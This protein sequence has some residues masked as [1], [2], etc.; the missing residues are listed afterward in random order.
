MLH[1]RMHVCSTG[2]LHLCKLLL[3]RWRRVCFRQESFNL[4]DSTSLRGKPRSWLRQHLYGSPGRR[5]GKEQPEA[6][7]FREPVT[8]CRIISTARESFAPPRPLQP[9]LRQ[10]ASARMWAAAGQHEPQPAGCTGGFE[11][12]ARRRASPMAVWPAR[13]AY[14]PGRGR[15][16]G[17]TEYGDGWPGGQ[18]CLGCSG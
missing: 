2:L 17:R 12:R 18:S 9:R 16:P 13:R 11:M 1:C 15:G 8:L 14:L 10:P 5:H 4:D 7:A 6:V 3:R